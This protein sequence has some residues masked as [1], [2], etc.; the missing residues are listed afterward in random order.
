MWDLR[1][2]RGRLLAARYSASREVLLF[3]AEI[4]DWQK[5]NEFEIRNSNFEF[6][7]PSL[8]D[9]VAQK[10]PS[11]LANAAA[12][13]DAS[14]FA[15]LVRA[16]RD[17]AGEFSPQQ[18]FVRAVLQPYAAAFPHGLDCPWCMRP[19]QAGCLKPQGEGLAFEIVCGLCLRRRSFPRAR[20]PGC[21]E[22][23]EQKIA[24]FTAPDF[25]H[26]RVQGCDS[27]RGYL[28]VVDLARDVSAIPEVDELAG[29]P[30]DLWAA[31]Q[32]YHKLLPNIAGI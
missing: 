29:M 14:R 5:Q 23:Q 15:E 28:L 10:G 6:V 30:L 20:C 17:S 12:D 7:F 26:L 32:E 19:P 1:A 27:C 8:R 16:H 9:L 18:F 21:G 11:A 31:G 24:T 22:S 2:A 13:L 3:Y 25:P 4:A